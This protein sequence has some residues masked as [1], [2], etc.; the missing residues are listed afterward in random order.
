MA[1]GGHRRGLLV[2]L[3][4]SV[5]AATGVCRPHRIVPGGDHHR[6]ALVRLHRSAQAAWL[7]H[8]A[9]CREATTAGTRSC[10]CTAAPRRRASPTPLRA[11]RRPPPARARAI[12][13][14]GGVGRVAAPIRGPA[15]RRFRSRPDR[16]A[17]PVAAEPEGQRGREGDVGRKDV[18]GRQCEVGRGGG[19]RPA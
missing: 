15:R 10:D 8:T 14:Q 6:R 5:S 9:P 4:R 7:T 13:P 17:V 3:R 16:S 1:G 2:R 11:G 12:S 19:A 18:V